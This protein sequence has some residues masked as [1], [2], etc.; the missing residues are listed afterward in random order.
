MTQA[1]I[2][3]SEAT[4]KSQG[5]GRLSFSSPEEARTAKVAM[6][7]AVVNVKPVRVSWWNG[8][9]RR[10]ED[11][12]SADR[13]KLSLRTVDIAGRALKAICAHCGPTLKTHQFSLE[14]VQLARV[15]L[16]E[17]ENTEAQR[18][19]LIQSEL[20][21]DAEAARQTAAR[22]LRSLE[23]QKSLM[24]ARIRSEALT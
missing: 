6:R 7:D 11:K 9:A 1:T 2:F 3:Y 13:V 12:R 14:V 17:I 18:R 20:E 16:D 10:R 8:A 15:A 5:A 24:T 21:A 19:A 22:H 4:Q 23:S